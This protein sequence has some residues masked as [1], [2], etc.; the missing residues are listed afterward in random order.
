MIEKNLFSPHL[1][2]KGFGGAENGCDL[3]VRSEG[4]TSST[5]ERQKAK[6][7]LLPSLKTGWRI[8]V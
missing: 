6:D 8:G 1:S 7:Y 5:A 3:V 4:S 2:L